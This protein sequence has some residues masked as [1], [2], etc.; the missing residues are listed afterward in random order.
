MFSK[1]K[2]VVLSVPKTGTTAL[3]EVLG[4]RA[5]LV[6]SDPPELKHAPVYRYNR[7][8]RPMIEKFVGE[9]EVVALI[10]E[11]RS[12]L[13]SW[14]RYR[15]RP[16]LDGRPQSTAQMDFAGFIEGWLQDPRPPY[17]NIGS[18]AAF[19]EGRPN[20]TRVDRLFRYEDFETF[21]GFLEARLGCTID[22]PRRNVSPGAAL[23][24]PAEL[25]ARLE[26][27]T[28]ADRALW[29]AADGQCRT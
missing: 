2:L 1:A 16:F 28:E 25:A 13:G 8:F 4:G 12:W 22:L 9:V 27:A 10:R 3:E 29:Q 24:L 5:A 21:T 18:Q 6:V 14:F 17:A 23:D 19:L 26:A 15:Q 11:P 20:G 7:F